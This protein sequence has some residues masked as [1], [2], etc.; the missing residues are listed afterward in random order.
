M[1]EYKTWLPEYSARLVI[2]RHRWHQ[3]AESVRVVKCH[4][5]S[6]LKA[7]GAGSSASSTPYVLPSSCS[8]TCRKCRDIPYSLFVGPGPDPYVLHN[9][10]NQLSVS[11]DAGCCLCWFFVQHLR[12]VLQ[13]LESH[14]LHRSLD[15]ENSDFSSDLTVTLR[16][17]GG[18]QQPDWILL[19]LGKFATRIYWTLAED[20]GTFR[21]PILFLLA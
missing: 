3:E 8:A 2:T 21:K 10:Y 17:G 18:V 15:D 7:G 5:E 11:A 13:I 4:S 20:C 9:N 16:R 12:Q 1:D 19:F 6:G 14:A